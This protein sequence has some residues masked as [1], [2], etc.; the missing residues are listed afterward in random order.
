MRLGV[1]REELAASLS[2]ADR[3]WMYQP[4]GLDWNLDSVAAELGERATIAHE[5][6]HL[7]AALSAE[8]KRGDRVLI[9]SNGGFGGLHERL[10]QALRTRPA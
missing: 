4:K 6:P 5:L 1:H 7:L 9:M 8:L 3:I 2:G 10:L